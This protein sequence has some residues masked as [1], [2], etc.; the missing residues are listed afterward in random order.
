[1]LLLVSVG[2]M[3]DSKHTYTSSCSVITHSNNRAFTRKRPRL[4]LQMNLKF[5]LKETNEGRVAAPSARVRTALSVSTH[6]MTT[7]PPEHHH[8]SAIWVTAVHMRACEPLLFQRWIQN[9][10]EYIV[11]RL[12]ISNQRMKKRSSI[13]VFLPLRL[14]APHC[15]NINRN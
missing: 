13:S 3:K 4:N 2:V 6:Q 15:H 7:C 8:L 10:T 5:L 12:F 14:E 11:L 9:K 1:M